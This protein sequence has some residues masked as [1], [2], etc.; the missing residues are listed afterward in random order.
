MRFRTWVAVF[1][2]SAAALHGCSDPPIVRALDSCVAWCGRLAEC[3]V[4][5]LYEFD[6]LAHCEGFCDFHFGF[7]DSQFDGAPDFPSSSLDCLEEA[8]NAFTCEHDLS[9][10]ELED[11]GCPDEYDR[12]LDVCF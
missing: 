11:E 10:S 12:Y 5:D 3:N 1:A 9:C 7:V 8:V 6:D 4:L 2:V